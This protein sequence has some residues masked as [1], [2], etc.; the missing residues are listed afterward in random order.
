M[1]VLVTGGAGFIGAHVVE[2]LVRRGDEVSVLDVAG[3]GGD[4]VRAIQSDVRDPV[5]VAGALDGA[6]VVV[7]L[8]ARV[9]VRESLRHAA[10]YEAVN[11]GGTRV[12]MDALARRGGGRVVFASSSSIYGAH[13]GAP[14]AEDDP[15]GCPRSPYAAS[16]RAAEAVGRAGWRAAGIPFTAL[17]LFTVYGP[18]QRPGMAIA[19]FVRCALRGEPLPVYGDGTSARDY[20]WVGDVVSAV[21]AAIDHPDGFQAINVG[22]GAPVSLNALVRALER[23]LGERLR[24]AHLP[25][26]P[27][28]VPVT[29]ADNRKAR[30]RLGWKPEVGIDEGLRSYVA[31]ARSA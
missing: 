7:H 17:R 31:W 25:E 24:V 12:L 10:E 20:T 16:K 27:G 21:L 23:V 6:E 18:H 22:P 19:R 2:A 15:A 14:S 28:D 13:D 8:A 29:H 1:K 9:G 11:V 4:R 26:Q 5:A 3:G 30:E